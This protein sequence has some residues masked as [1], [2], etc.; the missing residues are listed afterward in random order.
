MK[1]RVDIFLARALRW[2]SVSSGDELSCISSFSLFKAYCGGLSRRIFHVV[3]KNYRSTDQSP[4]KIRF[5]K[6]YLGFFRGNAENVIFLK[7][8]LL[9]GVKSEMNQLLQII[10]YRILKFRFWR[11]FKTISSIKWT[12]NR[13]L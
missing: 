6:K 4:L 7:N 2:M 12:Q 5:T 3:I 13:H 9:D 8:M 11:K 1:L 10:T